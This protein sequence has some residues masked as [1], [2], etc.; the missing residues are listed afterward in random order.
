MEAPEVLYFLQI[1]R[2]FSDA[3]AGEVKNRIAKCGSEWGQAGLAH[4]ASGL[5]HAA[6]GLVIVHD[7]HFYIGHL[8]SMQLKR[9]QT[10]TDPP[11][12]RKFLASSQCRWLAKNL[13]IS[14]GIKINVAIA[15]IE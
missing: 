8:V 14:A 10:E 3:S 15:I 11:A 6:S 2:Q 9:G 13:F 7:V 1:K 4:A 12:I 5:V